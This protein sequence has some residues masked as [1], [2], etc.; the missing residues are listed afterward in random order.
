MPFFLDFEGEG[1]ECLGGEGLATGEDGWSDCLDGDAATLDFATDDEAIF[2]D[3]KEGRDLGRGEDGWLGNVLDKVV[4]DMSTI[5]FMA[6]A[7]YLMPF[8]KI[9]GFAVMAFVATEEATGE[10]MRDNN[11]VVSFFCWLEVETIALAS[12]PALS[13]EYAPPRVF[14]ILET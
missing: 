7:F 2:F 9:R 5:D 12:V 11:G 4:W 6:R 14:T 13:L 1:L 10:L 8:G 3:D